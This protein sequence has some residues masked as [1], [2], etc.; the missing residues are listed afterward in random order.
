MSIEN[1][2]FTKWLKMRKD[3]LG[4][5]DSADDQKDIQ[6]AIKLLDYYDRHIKYP[7]V[8]KMTMQEIKDYLESTD[9]MSLSIEDLDDEIGKIQSI[10]SDTLNCGLNAYARAEYL[11]GIKQARVT[12]MNTVQTTDKDGVK[13]S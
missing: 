12:L 6:S 10:G 2:D 1:I 4:S 13:R 7:D 8:S 9:P 3:H 11:N 5:E